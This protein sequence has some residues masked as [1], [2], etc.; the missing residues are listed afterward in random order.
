MTLKQ[1]ISTMTLSGLMV[2]MIGFGNTVRAQ[3]QLEEL[4]AA[5]RCQ[6]YNNLDQGQ[7]YDLRGC[8]LFSLHAETGDAQIAWSGGNSDGAVCPGCLGT[9]SRTGREASNSG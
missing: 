3:D 9:T 6:D 4:Y 5:C 7:P 8:H 1:M 2:V